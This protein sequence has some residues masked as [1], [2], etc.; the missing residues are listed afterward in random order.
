ME[1][2]ERGNRI[3]RNSDFGGDRY[4]YDLNLCTRANGWVQY[5]TKQDAWYFGVWIHSEKRQILT[6]AEGDV[7]VVHCK[8]EES[9]HEELKNM[10]EFYGSPPWAFK[11]FGLDGTVREF[12][13]ERPT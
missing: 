13:D 1:T 5:D 7:S 8:S 6:Y 4:K 9:Y 11:S 12:Y 2:N 3:E 10:A